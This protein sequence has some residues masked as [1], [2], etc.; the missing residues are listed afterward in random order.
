MAN[1]LV[2][3]GRGFIGTYLVKALRNRGHRVI[4]YDR[5]KAAHEDVRYPNFYAE[6]WDYIYHL[7]S[8]V[9]V[10][11]INAMPAQDIIDEIVNGT[12][13][14]CNVAKMVGAKLIFA[15][16]S[17]VY[18]AGKYQFGD[19]H[20]WLYGMGKL[21]SEHLV[22]ELDNY[23]ILRYFNVYGIG[24]THGVISKLV[25]AAR[26][27]GDICVN[28]HVRTF[29]Y[30]DDAIRA[31][32]AA[33]GFDGVTDVGTTEQ[34]TIRG[35]SVLVEGIF[36]NVHRHETFVDEPAITT[37]MPEKLWIRSREPLTL[38]QGLEKMKVILD[39]N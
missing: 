17:E 18:G 38:K 28:E 15:S 35:A 16:S 34:H 4:T 27:H 5:K 6:N 29:I 32:V 2:T 39:E 37:R 10:D 20:R 14:V 36:G 33:I 26:V 12:M 9:G 23:C 25:D 11:K 1:I 21:M 3:G 22:K 13:A 31:T 30:I 7:A 8:P 24:D 19:S